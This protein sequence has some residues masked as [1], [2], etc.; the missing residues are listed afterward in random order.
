[1]ESTETTPTVSTGDFETSY[2]CGACGARFAT[3]RDL[4]R[5]RRTVGLID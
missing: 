2:V 5:H 1:M 4:R 3:L